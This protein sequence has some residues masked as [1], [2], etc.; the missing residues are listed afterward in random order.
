MKRSFLYSLVCMLLLGVTACVDDEIRPWDDIPEG[1][2]TVSATVEFNPLMPALETRAA[3][4]NAI[5]NIGSLCVLVYG[6]DGN[7]I[8]KFPIKKSDGSSEPGYAYKEGELPRKD[9]KPGRDTIAES[10]TPYAQFKLKLPYG[11]YHIYAV[12][13]MGDM[14]SYED[15]IQ[16]IDGLKQISLGWQSDV[17]KNNQMLGHFTE[18]GVYSDDSYVLTIN[19]KNMEL[20]AGLRRVASKVTVAF[21]GSKLNEGVFIYIKSVRI[22]DIPKTCFLGDKNTP[23]SRENDLMDGDTIRYDLQKDEEGNM[24][25]A[26][27]NEY[28]LARI[29][30]G[31]PYFP[32]QPDDPYQPNFH[33]ETERSLF[34]YENMQGVHEDKDKRQDADGKNGLDHPGTSDPNKPQPPTYREKDG[35]ECGTYIEVEAYYNS[36]HPDRVG[37]GDIVYRFMLG[38]N[39]TTDYNAERNHHYKLTLKFNK[40]ANDVDWHIDYKEPE[41]TIEVPEPYYISYLYNHQ[42]NVPVRISTGGS[43]LVSFRADIDTNSWAPHNVKYLQY[44]DDLDPFNKAFKGKV[45]KNFNGFLSLRKTKAT[46]VGNGTEGASQAEAINKQYYELHH[47]GDREYDVQTMG[48]NGDEQD[49]FYT[50][51]KSPDNPNI[52]NISVPMWTRAK[53]LVKACGYTGN[54]PYVAYQRKAI[55]KYTAVLENAAG[56]RT[57][58]IE[59]GTILQ[60]RRVVNPKGIW[61]KHDG[62]EPFHVVLKRLPLEKA[63]VFETFVSEGKW[64]AYQVR[65]DKGFIKL[66]TADRAEQ[67][68]VKGE[69]GTL[70]DFTVNFNGGCAADQNRFAI[71]RVEYHDYSCYH[72]IFVRQGSAPVKLMDGSK[73]LWHTCNMR[74][75]TTET[76][77]PLEEGS[78]FKFGNW[79]QPIDA[80][81]NENRFKYGE[82]VTP[83]SFGSDGGWKQ[84]LIA[85]TTEKSLWGDIRFSNN[86]TNGFSDPTVNNKKI[87]VATA[88]DY[89]ELW[90]HE[91]IAFGFGV[92]YGNDGTETLTQVEDV[93]SHR[94]DKHKAGGGGYGM[95]GVFVY[96]MEN[97]RNLFF[98]IGASGYG[99][100]KRKDGLNNGTATA[101]LRYANRAEYMP[102]DATYATMPIFYDL[103]MRPGAIYWL[104]KSASITRT[105]EDG[106]KTTADDVLGWDFNYF[107]FDFNFID[108]SNIHDDNG[109][110]ACFVRCVE[111]EN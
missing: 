24:A 50:V 92:M 27:F 95:R 102:R 32:Y 33:T 97:G 78:L 100:R 12:A 86:I 11:R 54:N 93:Y 29:A 94:Y 20:R 40:F 36:I 74:T 35:V 10:S 73:T 71:I 22:K 51:S 72:L 66:S 30:R 46:I 80:I 25:S 2:T 108:R 45:V 83:A 8:E 55:V 64:K 70:I 18:K 3:A 39:V 31:K 76:G 99:R 106:K 105:S 21:D 101:V 62:K 104:K 110:D 56:V 69:T 53:L 58:L 59:H 14:A 17:T 91:D 103:F 75:G 4:G 65:G 41:P 13:N 60:V 47:R 7:L 63:S 89:N 48:V 85:G 15:K 52:I 9:P 96:N 49:G 57:T 98:P 42:V 5:K 34:F 111:Y 79:S 23:T 109:S 84:F 19:R 61:R 87:S 28:Y 82:E 44:R 16:T 67:D 68:T 6:L 38:K 1:E 26:P 43:K 37:N 90:E 88:E 107:S 81:N 77:C